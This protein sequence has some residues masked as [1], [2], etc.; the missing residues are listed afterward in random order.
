MLVIIWVCLCEKR[1]I[2]SKF[3]LKVKTQQRI[4]NA[5]MFMLSV[6][7]EFLST[8]AMQ[9]EGLR[10]RNLFSYVPDLII[11]YCEYKYVWL[12]N[13]RIIINRKRKQ[14]FWYGVNIPRNNTY[15]LKSSRGLIQT[16]GK[17]MCCSAWPHDANLKIIGVF[18]ID[19]QCFLLLIRFK[20]K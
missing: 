15:E 5:V 3:H 10:I 12:R 6:C 9:K 2:R 20:Q 7:Y 8:T 11:R 14:A 16:V 1:D 13:T 19:F 18:W 17:K 4:Q